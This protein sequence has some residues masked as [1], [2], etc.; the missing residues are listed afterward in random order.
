VTVAPWSNQPGRH[1]DPATISALAIDGR[2]KPDYGAL[3]EARIV[4]GTPSSTLMKKPLWQLETRPSP[5]SDWSRLY[6]SGHT[7]T[8]RTDPIK[9]AKVEGWILVS[10]ED[11]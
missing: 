7:S 5:K 4:R 11:P 8:S 2:S 9:T 1:V 6:G 10:D 3:M